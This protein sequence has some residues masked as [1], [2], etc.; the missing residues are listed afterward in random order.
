MDALDKLLFDIETI[1]AI[2]RG[3]KINTS[4]EFINVEESGSFQGVWRA[5]NRE[6]REKT[7]TV[8][9]Q[10]IEL[11][12]LV[13]DLSLDSK[14][15]IKTSNDMFDLEYEKCILNIKRIHITLDSSCNGINALI[16]TYSH[17]SNV[18]AKLK[19]LLAKV[20]NQISKITHFLMEV[21]EYTDPKTNRLYINIMK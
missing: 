10:R 17:D 1:G 20:G 9:C 6:N 19:P 13:C 14:W 8:I 5:I 11:L 15:L 4:G 21:G 7:V 3:E 2:K 16:D 18:V 12:I